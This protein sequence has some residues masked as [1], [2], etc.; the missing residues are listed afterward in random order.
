[1]VDFRKRI[2][3]DITIAMNEILIKENTSSN[4]SNN[5]N[6]DDK[7][8]ND[9]SSDDSNEG[10][11][12]IDATCTPADIAYPQDLN[13]LNLAREKL[14]GYIDYLHIPSTD[15]KRKTYRNRARKDFLNVSKAKKKGVKNC[16]KL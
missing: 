8:D 11:I 9:N 12:I 14:E 6:N 4:Q 3:D 10:T 1:M 5:E 16:V 13:L 2:S 7:D 15:K